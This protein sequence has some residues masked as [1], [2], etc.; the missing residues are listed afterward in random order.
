MS[1]VASLVQPVSRRAA[2]RGAKSR[3]LVVPP[4]KT[5]EG[6]YLRQRTVKRFV[7]ASV[8]YLS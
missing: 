2:K 3:P 1:S 8:L 7:Y 4:T 5:A 6:L